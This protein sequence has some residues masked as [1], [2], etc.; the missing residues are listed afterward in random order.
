MRHKEGQIEYFGKRGM[1]LLGG[2]LVRRVTRLKGGIERLGL[3]YTFIDTVIDKHSSQDNLQVMAAM[4][5]LFDMGNKEKSRKMSGERAHALLM[6]DVAQYDWH[7]QV[8]MSVARVKG[9]FGMTT[10]N[11]QKLI[12]ELSNGQA[13]GEEG[14]NDASLLL[15]E[16]VREE[17]IAIATAETEDIQEEHTVIET[18]VEPLNRRIERY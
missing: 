12:R 18:R 5:Q 4:T 14:D 2:M 16:N 13:Q 11:H 8:I 10:A 6:E 7:E 9:V 3:E 15:E 17:E 1:S